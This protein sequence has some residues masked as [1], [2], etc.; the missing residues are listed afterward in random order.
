MVH[1]SGRF[2]PGAVIK[3]F[4][5]GAFALL[6]VKLVWEPS[7]RRDREQSA[8]LGQTKSIPHSGKFPPSPFFFFFV[9]SGYLFLMLAWTYG[10]G[11]AVSP[12]S[13]KCTS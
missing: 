5:M 4:C 9:E 8:L 2:F 10:S 11:K 3:Y 12:N 1:R 6:L 13:I 7:R